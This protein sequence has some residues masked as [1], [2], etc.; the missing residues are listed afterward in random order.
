AA[1]RASCIVAPDASVDRP[2]W[3]PD[4]RAILVVAADPVG[5]NQTELLAYTSVRPSSPRAADWRSQG[6]VTDGL[7]GKLAGEGVAFAA[8]S[9]DGTR[10]AFAANWSSP[11]LRAFRVF[12]G[13]FD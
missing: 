4:G 8:F 13:R 6:L 1:P 2:A 12:V 11:D 10:V 7:H 3:S 5:P 9:P